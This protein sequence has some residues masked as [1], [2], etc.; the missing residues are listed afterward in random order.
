MT[1]NEA[2]D[3]GQKLSFNLCQIAFS[4]PSAWSLYNRASCKCPHKFFKYTQVGMR[5]QDAAEPRVCAGVVLFRLS[6]YI[7]SCK[8]SN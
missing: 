3:L 5:C 6:E 7:V 4:N 8:T 1:V 2:S